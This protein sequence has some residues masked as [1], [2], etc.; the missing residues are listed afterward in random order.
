VDIQII[1]RYKFSEKD[2]KS[3]DSCQETGLHLVPELPGA[4]NALSHLGQQ[5]AAAAFRSPPQP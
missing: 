1:Y 4:A 2:L 3:P 5:L